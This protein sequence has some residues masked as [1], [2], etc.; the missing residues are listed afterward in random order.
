LQPFGGYW[1]KVTQDGYLFMNS[2]ASQMI[3][4]AATAGVEPT[5][6]SSLNLLTIG[7]G[8]GNEQTLLFGKGELSLQD[9][10][11]LPPPA[12]AGGFDVR[13]TSGSQAALVNADAV[14]EFP[15]A[16]SEESATISIGW[17][18]KDPS[19]HAALRIGSKAVQLTGKG[20]MRVTNDGRRIVLVLGAAEGLPKSYALEQNYPNPFNPAT[21]IRYDL[22]ATSHVVL[23][24]YNILGQEVTTLIDNVIPGGHNSQAWDGSALSSGVYFYRLEATSV[25]DPNMRFS[26]IRKMLLVK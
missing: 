19:Q 1:V 4:A 13:F 6:R 22:P 14:K 16:I 8:S 11:E 7:N 21:N 23:K 25:A 17:E 12:P 24:I 9:S 2:G 5:D 3:P 20:E 10:Y 15:I 18:I 26:A